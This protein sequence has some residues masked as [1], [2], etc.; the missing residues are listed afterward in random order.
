MSFIYKG[1]LNPNAGR[2]IIGGPDMAQ[3]LSTA[4]IIT[5]SGVVAVGN[6]LSITTAAAGNGIV[7]RRY[8]SAGD[9][10]LGVCLSVADA[11]GTQA[12][13]DSG[14]TDTWTV[15]SDNETVAKKYAVVDISPWSIWSASLTGTIHTTAAFGL[16][17][18]CDPNT[19]TNSGTILESGITGTLAQ[20]RGLACI[21]VDPDDT[22]R[23]LVV[24]GPEH[25]IYGAS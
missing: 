1:T 16:G 18:W 20:G 12:E 11:D 19:G 13:P 14:T 15:A 10:I 22:T 3:G 5:N 17:R 25:F 23:G 9:V 21:G 2:M 7:A 4:T 24:F 8:N 6:V